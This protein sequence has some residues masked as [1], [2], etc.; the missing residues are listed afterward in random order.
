M[1]LSSH[2]KQKKKINKKCDPTFSSWS[3]S[4]GLSCL[5][6]R[7]EGNQPSSLLHQR[8]TE[9]HHCRRVFF[10]MY[11]KRMVQV[12]VF[13]SD[14]FSW[15]K[16]GFNVFS[17]LIPSVFIMWQHPRRLIPDYI[18]V[19]KQNFSWPMIRLVVFSSFPTSG[20][21]HF[22][23]YTQST[24]ERVKEKEEMNKYGLGSAPSAIKG[25]LCKAFRAAFRAFEDYRRRV[26][27]VR[28]Y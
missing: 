7:R 5:S 26:Y 13:F 25:S 9:D 18:K 10:N 19:V 15:D 28:N 23:T 6:R 8:L 11:K 17:S 21:T 3:E 24:T 14:D 20:I 4:A 1:I 27:F 16:G 12:C 2:K 22:I